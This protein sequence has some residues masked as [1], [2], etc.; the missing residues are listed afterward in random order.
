[1]H[2]EIRTLMRA[3]PFT[4][5]TIFMTDGRS[6]G[7]LTSDHVSIMPSGLIVVEDDKRVVNLLPPRQVAGVESQSATD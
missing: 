4:P 5:F 1:M 2:E 3:T 6:F 7:I